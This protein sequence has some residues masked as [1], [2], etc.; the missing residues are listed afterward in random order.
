MARGPWNL[1]MFDLLPLQDVI[2]TEQH[3]DT[4]FIFTSEP[5]NL[6]GTA[7]QSGDSLRVNIKFWHTNHHHSNKDSL[8]TAAAARK[9][10]ERGGES[11]TKVH[12]L[13]K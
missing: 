7:T 12:F 5:D 11:C 8:A 3:S 10:I 4:A 2:H 6:C 9:E 1:F 13:L